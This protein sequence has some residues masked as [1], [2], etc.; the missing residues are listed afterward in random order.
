MK[1]LQIKNMND[2]NLHKIKKEICKNGNMEKL[3]D[4][5]TV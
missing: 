1:G 2:R 5:S 4:Y 3:T